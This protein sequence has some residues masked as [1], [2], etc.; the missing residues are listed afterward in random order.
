MSEKPLDAFATG[1]TEIHTEITEGPSVYAVNPRAFPDRMR[2]SVRELLLDLI[3]FPSTRGQEGP[4]IRYLYEKMAPLVD[5]CQLVE[6]GD[7]LMQDPDYAFPLPGHSNRDTPN[8]ECVIRGSGEGR[9]VV[10]NTHLDV[11]PPS[12]DQVDPFVPREE[13]GI[14]FGRGACDAKGQAA[15]LYTLALLLREQGIRPGGDVTFHFV[16]EEENGGN[17]TLTMVRRGVKADAAVVLE[18]TEMAVVPAV[19]GAV[20]FELQLFGRAGHSGSQGGRISA[21]DKAIQAKEILRRYHDRLLAAARGLPHFDRFQD[22]MPLTFGQC[23]AGNWPASVPARATL[24]GVLGFLPNHRRE[25]VQEGMRQ[26]LLAEG[27]EWLREHFELSFPMLR[28]DGNM[29]PPDH[30]L[31]M[32]LLAA[33]RRQGF[34]ERV[35]AMTGSCDAWFY[36]NRAGIPTVV[37]GPGS[38]QYAHSKEEQ[39]SLEEILAAAAVLAEFVAGL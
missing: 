22:P 18:P 34:P 19:R 20:W 12:D 36:N 13:N 35:T 21:L 32:S 26:A 30:P 31:V 37:F 15:T 3:R 1:S 23:V 17:G 39:V 10:F 9:S 38:L 25:Q 33:V 27:D 4:A 6:I 29:I 28:S 14:I 16:V 24:K 8:L 7:D 5:R 11:V 2:A